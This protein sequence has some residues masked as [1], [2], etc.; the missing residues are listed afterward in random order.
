[1]THPLVRDAGM[2]WPAPRDYFPIVYCA[3]AIRLAMPHP[4][5]YRDALERGTAA[6]LSLHRDSP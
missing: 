4:P 5:D 2:H 1:M 3:F 6:P